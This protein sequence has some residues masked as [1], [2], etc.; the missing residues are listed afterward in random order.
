MTVRFERRLA[1]RF[2]RDR[3]W[4]AGDAAHMTGP[5]GVQGV[6]VGLREA[7]DL[8]ERIAGIVRNQV[9]ADVLEG[10]NND[11]LAEWRR[12]FGLEGGLSAGDQ[13]DPWVRERIPR[14]GQCIPAAAD[15][16]AR[17]AAQMGLIVPRRAG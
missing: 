4:L 10:Y 3:C 17:L 7:R 6:N 5:V 13:C 1:S 11:R 8:V 12:L 9:P 16:Y 2:G 15:H 14:L